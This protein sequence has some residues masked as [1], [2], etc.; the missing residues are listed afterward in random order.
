[1]KVQGKVLAMKALSKKQVVA[2]GIEKH[3]ME[4]RNIGMMLDHP[5]LVC[6]KG[7]FQDPKFLYMFQQPV[8]GGELYAYLERHNNDTSSTMRGISEPEAKFYAGCVLYGLEYLH[9]RSY[10]YRDLKPE[11]CLIDEQGYV[12]ITDFGFVKKVVDR[13]YTMCGTIDYMAPEILMRKGHNKEVDIWAFGVLI[14]EMTTHGTP[15]EYCQ[16]D[17]QRM[18]AVRKAKFHCPKYLSSECVDLMKKIIEPVPMKRLGCMKEGTTS[19]RSHQWFRGFD[20]GALEKRTM[21]PLFVPKIK[22]QTDVSNLEPYPDD[23]EHPG[24]DFEREGASA[25]NKNTWRDW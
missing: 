24:E 12:K 9:N 2:A 19:I 14:F 23:M 20:W 22:S 21:E 1:V 11:N 18:T 8:L 7:T 4:E 3:V 5:F 15:F 16:D 10:C 6:L 17:A 13:T 25:G